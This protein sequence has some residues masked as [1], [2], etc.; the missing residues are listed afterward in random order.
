MEQIFIPE[1]GQWGLRGDPHLWNSLRVYLSGYSDAL[2]QLFT[3][4]R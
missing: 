2:K 1:P 4:A 3:Y